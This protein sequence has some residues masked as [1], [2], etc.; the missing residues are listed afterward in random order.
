MARLKDKKLERLVAEFAVVYRENFYRLAYSYVKNSDDALD[1]VQESI[2][3][4]ISAISTLE[5][6][7]SLKT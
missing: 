4:A 3:K 6:P 5:N 7:D 1:I 2:Y